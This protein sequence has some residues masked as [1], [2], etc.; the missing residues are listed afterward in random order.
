[1]GVTRLALARFVQVGRSSALHH[2]RFCLIAC[3]TDAFAPALDF[4]KIARLSACLAVADVS[5]HRNHCRSRILVLDGSIDFVVFLE[6]SR[7]R[8]GARAVVATSRRI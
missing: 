3:G 7:K 8:P 5:S 2:L 4:S 1:M 6:C